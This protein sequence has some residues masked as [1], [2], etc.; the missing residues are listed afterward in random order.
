MLTDRGLATIVVSTIFPILAI[1]AFGLRIYA[2]RIKAHAFH[3]DDY[4]CL[5]ATIVTVASCIP[6]IIGA[7]IGGIGKHITDL[8]NDELTRFG[9]VMKTLRKLLNDQ[10]RYLPPPKILFALQ[11]TYLA[12]SSLTKISILIFYKRVFYTA[13]FALAANILIVHVS[14]WF[15]AFFIATLFQAL[16]ISYNWN[17]TV[18]A[19]YVINEYAMYTA[20]GAIEIVLDIAT[21]CLPIPVIWIL[22]ISTQKKWIVSG[23]FLL[24]G[25]TCL[26]SII[27]LHYLIAYLSPAAQA[28]EDFTYDLANIII[29]SAI[30]PCFGI[31]CACLPTLGPVFRGRSTESLVG[32]LRRVT[33]MFGGGS[34][35]S[36]GSGKSGSAGA[37]TKESGFSSRSESLKDVSELVGGG[38]RVGD[39][40]K[41]FGALS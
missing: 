11:F 28:S 26:T 14:L 7:A 37:V 34:G 29:W 16:P 6:Y 35:G 32:S 10:V 1:I 22:K 36:S 5:V 31:V 12:A 15:M 39:C 19:T 40:E 3:L 30:E 27:R 38:G 21:L 41:A 8:S 18:T 2:R 9:K 33:G 23:V 24:G 20:A 13:R 25:F 4:L 17:L